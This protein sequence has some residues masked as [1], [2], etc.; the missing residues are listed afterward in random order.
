[1][2]NKTISRQRDQLVAGFQ[3]ERTRILAN[4]KAERDVMQTAFEN[5]RHLW[6]KQLDAANNTVQRSTTL[7]EQSGNR[8][9]EYLLRAPISNAPV[10]I[11]EL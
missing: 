10:V 1:M 7:V 11:G 5:E 3:E 4:S 6:V 9:N 8:L 2:F